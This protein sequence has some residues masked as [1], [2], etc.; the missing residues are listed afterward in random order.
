FN[1]DGTI[2]KPTAA[3]P[4]AGTTLTTVNFAP[5]G[6]EPLV[7]PVNYEQAT[8]FGGNFNYEFVQDGYPTGEY[9][10]MAVAKDGTVVAN[11]TNGEMLEV[12]Y[13]V[14]ADFPAIQGL[15]P[16]GGNA[17]AQTPE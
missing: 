12:G 5:A 9:A 8:Q 4:T 15:S 1:P 16:V 6:A 3:D 14:L 13:I 2:E 11:Y 10:S 7:I 17:W